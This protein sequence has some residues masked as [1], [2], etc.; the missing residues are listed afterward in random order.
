MLRDLEP[1]LLVLIIQT[2]LKY[3]NWWHFLW[4]MEGRLDRMVKLFSLI[5]HKTLV[6]YFLLQLKS[7]SHLKIK[8]HLNK[9]FWIFHKAVQSHQDVKYH[10]STL[11]SWS[12]SMTLETCST[13][14]TYFQTK[15]SPYIVNYLN[16]VLYAFAHI[17]I[18][19]SGQH[20]VEGEP[21]QRSE[22]LV[23]LLAHG[24]ISN[25]PH[26]QTSFPTGNSDAS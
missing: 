15:L 18:T 19:G 10:H 4:K 9:Q 25:T 12:N 8:M 20:L 22:G 2:S 11:N 24:R 6:S 16:L 14:K 1:S 5:L 17:L 3:L 13:I 23:P 7:N 21:R 26:N